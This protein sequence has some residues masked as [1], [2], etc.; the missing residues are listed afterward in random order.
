MAIASM[1]CGIVGLLWLMFAAIDNTIF[2]NYEISANK[3]LFCIS[4]ILV[5]L[6]ILFGIIKRKDSK[7]KKYHVPAT[8]GSIAGLLGVI[9]LLAV[10]FVHILFEKDYSLSTPNSYYTQ[11]GE[12]K[13][14][15]GDLEPYTV[16]VNIIL[17][18]NSSDKSV[19]NELTKKNYLLR[20]LIKGYFES[21]QVSGIKP[22][23][24]KEIRQEILELI[25]TH[26]LSRARIQ[27]I[28]F[29][30]FDLIKM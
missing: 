12:V 11:I 2:F 25:N 29:I 23:N 30:Q 4:L 6:A 19:A 13:A 15:T 14:N 16:V 9:V 27:S 7:G 21:K 18:Y 26:I 24:E 17:G 1:I 20:D 8:V 22:E 3:Y 5:L 10:I 28:Y